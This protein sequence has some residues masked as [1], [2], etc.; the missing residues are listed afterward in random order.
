MLTV[1]SRCLVRRGSLTG[2]YVIQDGRAILRWLRV[3]QESAD[4]VEVMAGLATGD[5]IATEPEKLS[6]GRRV[7]SRP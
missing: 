1:P 2:V 5:E 6:D 3:G 7:Q 4:W